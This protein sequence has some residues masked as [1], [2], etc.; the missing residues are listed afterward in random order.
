MEHNHRGQA[1]TPSVTLTHLTSQDLNRPNSTS[2]TIA[3]HESIGFIST[4][5][6]GGVL[7]PNRDGRVRNP[8]PSKLKGKTDTKQGNFAVMQMG[9]SSGK[10]DT[11]HGR[12]IAAE[13]DAAALKTSEA[14]VYRAKAAQSDHY[15]PPTRR[16]QD[17]AINH[18]SVSGRLPYVPPE[19]Q[20]PKS[21]SPMEIKRE[22]ARL[23]V[24]LKIISPVTVVDQICKAIAYFGGVPGASPPNDGVFPESAKTKNNGA[25]FIEWL[26]EIFPDVSIQSPKVFGDIRYVRETKGGGNKNDSQAEISMSELPNS[27]NGTNFGMS[28]SRVASGTS[29]NASDPSPTTSNKRK[30]GRPKGSRN[31]KSIGLIPETK[32]DNKAQ[33]SSVSYIESGLNSSTIN[34]STNQMNGSNLEASVTQNPE[35]LLNQ[36]VDSK[37]N[38][39]QFKKPVWRPNQQNAPSK[40]GQNSELQSGDNF[41][42]EE[43]AVLKAFRD[44]NSKNLNG[45]PQKS[46]L[47]NP[48]PDSSNSES[49]PGGFLHTKIN[50]KMTAKNSL[51][52]ITVDSSEPSSKRIKQGK[53][54]MSSTNASPSQNPDTPGISNSSQLLSPNTPG[55]SNSSHVLSANAPGMNNSS[56]VLSSNTPYSQQFASHPQFYYGHQAPLKLSNSAYRGPNSHSHTQPAQQQYGQYSDSSFIDLPSSESL[57]YSGNSGNLGVSPNPSVR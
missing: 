5:V 17:G 21:L 24:L 31:K 52:W 39:E 55:M 56:Q 54:K 29:T 14:T 23:L 1:H 7:G 15:V 43:C 18:P 46:N 37:L 25:L 51:Q 2:A 8:V 20:R 35:L 13:R 26:A 32:I 41:S 48:L 45:P 42:P 33:N 22:Q 19:K 12:D 50:P 28:V 9:S 16:I 10:K 40:M 6:I 44:H 34:Q 49:L 3:S 36:S 57:G 4:S 53:P 27:S 30:R 38:L 47:S 11:A